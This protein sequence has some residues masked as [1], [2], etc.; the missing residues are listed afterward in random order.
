MNYTKILNLMLNL[1]IL[2]LFLL[3]GGTAEQCGSQAGGAL[4]PNNLCCSR[5]GWCGTGDDYCLV[6]NG[7]QSQCKDSTGGISN[8]ISSSMFDQMLKYRNDPSLTMQC[9]E[10]FYCSNSNE[11]PCAPGKQYYGRGPIQISYNFNY[12]PAGRAI[13]VDLLNNPDLVAQNAIISFKTAIWFGMTP[14][15]KKPSS[16]DVITGRWTPSD[17]DRAAGRVPGYGVITNIINGGVECGHGWDARVEDRIGFYKRY[18]GIFGVSTGDNLDCY[19][20]ASFGNSLL[21]KQVI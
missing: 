6:G 17:A 7:C 20:Q 5:W 18:C 15:G 2:T 9:F 19:N 3:H 16:H 4:C 11:W 10:L 13:G 1:L 12:G 14:Q 8:Y 21:I